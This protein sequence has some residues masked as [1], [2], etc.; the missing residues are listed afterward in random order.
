VVFKVTISVSDPDSFFTDPDPGFFLNP[1]PVP[2]PVPDPD[3]DSG[4]EKTFRRAIQKMWG[5]LRKLRKYVNYE[6]T[7]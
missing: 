2:Y 7:V 5:F 4:K 3:P 6:V 1:V